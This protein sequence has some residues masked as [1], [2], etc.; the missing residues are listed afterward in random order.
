M[1][2]KYLYN[3]SGRVTEREATVSGGS[4]GEIVALDGSGKID[5]TILPTGVG[6]ATVALTASESLTAGDFVNIWDDS[7]TTKCRKAD[8]TTNG[9][10]ADGFVLANVSSAATATVYLSGINN[11]LS[12]L[13]LASVHYLSTTAGGITTTA[14]S[15]AGNLVQFIGRNHSATALYFNPEEICTIA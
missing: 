10:K 14:P 12:G 13:T 9:K 11:Q 15:T 6:P 1:A 4:G 3:N 8:A 2:H 5:V 7:G